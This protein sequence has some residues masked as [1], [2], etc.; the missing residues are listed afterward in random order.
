MTCKKHDS[1]YTNLFSY[2]VSKFKIFLVFLKNK[3]VKNRS[4]NLLL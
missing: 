3:V 4:Y 1:D 2:I